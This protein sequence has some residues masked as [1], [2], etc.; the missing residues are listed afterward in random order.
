MIKIFLAV[1]VVMFV[2]DVYLSVEQ[3][4]LRK[5]NERLKKELKK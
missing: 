2:A 3:R 5:E 4:Q 1:V